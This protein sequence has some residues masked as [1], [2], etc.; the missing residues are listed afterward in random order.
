MAI[1]RITRI[2]GLPDYWTPGNILENPEDHQRDLYHDFTSG[3][4]PGILHVDE[5]VVS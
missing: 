4:L 3:D 2:T 1:F 5:L